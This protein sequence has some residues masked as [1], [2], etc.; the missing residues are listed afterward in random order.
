MKL[1]ERGIRLTW[2]V[3]AAGPG[4][5]FLDLCRDFLRSKSTD[6]MRR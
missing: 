3:N 1:T 5:D 2:S 4:N 6:L